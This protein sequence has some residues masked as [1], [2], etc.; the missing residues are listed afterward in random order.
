MDNKAFFSLSYGLFVVT[1][2]SDGRRG[3]CV[4]NTAM[5]VTAE[6]A[7][8]SITINKKNYTADLISESGV[9]AVSVLSQ[10]ADMDIISR[11]GF[12]SGREYDKLADTATAILE[13]IP[14]V[15]ESTNSAFACRV[16]DQVDVGTHIIFIGEVLDAVS[17]N[18][19]ESMTYS[20]YHK[21][22]KGTTPKNSPL[23]M[24]EKDSGYQCQV[25]GYIEKS[26][27]LPDGF[28]CPLCKASKDRFEKL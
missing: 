19:D 2:Q 7:R 24:K 20:Y 15:T 28:T 3:G 21:V 18:N 17:L 10:K 22:V 5:Q 11:F 16:V 4:I 6:P 12:K 26:D 14:Y 9:F 1:S 13:G 25:C 8:L 27:S 23:Y